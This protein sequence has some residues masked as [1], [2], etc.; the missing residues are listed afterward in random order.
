M[1]AAM[2]AHRG[3]VSNPEIFQEQVEVTIDALVAV[4]DLLELNDVT[5]V[6][7]NIKGTWLF[8]APPG[9]V[10]HFGDAANIIGLTRDEQ[11]PLPA[12]VRDRVV[13]RGVSRKVYPKEGEDLRA[14]LGAL[15]LREVSS[16]TWLRH[17][18]SVPV[19]DLIDRADLK[20]AASG[21]GGDLED[22]R[23]FNHTSESRNYRARWETAKGKSG[24]FVMRR[25]QAYGADR[26]GYGELLNGDVVKLFEF[27]EPEDRWRGCD[28]AW[29]LML[30]L[31]SHQG[32]A[33][34][35]RVEIREDMAGLDL[36]HPIPDWATRALIFTGKQVPARSCL[37][38]FD[39]PVAELSATEKFLET[40]LFLSRAA[41]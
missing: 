29:R 18:K 21:R 27:P 36:F 8:A 2:D 14:L 5:A 15:G 28:I 1:R 35:Y 11:T 40:F 24:R 38:S 10:I 17:P 23:V 32:R 20:L 33:V 41:D 37:L 7:E 22:L 31:Q 13:V 25:A 4:G 34:A 30:A 9:F 19:K 3:L 16:A 6:D 39:I 26:W 12:V